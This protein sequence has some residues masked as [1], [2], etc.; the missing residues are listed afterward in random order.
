MQ[1]VMRNGKPTKKMKEVYVRDFEDMVANGYMVE[2]HEVYMT[3]KD[4]QD[5]TWDYVPV[6]K[7]DGSRLTC[8]CQFGH[9]GTADHEVAYLYNKKTGKFACLSKGYNGATF[10]G[11]GASIKRVNW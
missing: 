6:Y 7:A 2:G 1:P 10:R 11:Y 8:V 5:A 3:D 9:Y 4:L